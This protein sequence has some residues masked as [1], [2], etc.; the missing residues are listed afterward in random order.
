MNAERY[1]LAKRVP[2]AFMCLVGAPVLG[3]WAGGSMP[4]PPGNG[5]GGGQVVV[6][7]AVPAILAFVSAAVARIRPAGAALWAVAS[8]APTGGLVLVLLWFVQT[9]V[10]T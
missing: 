10:P 3:V 2:L 1:G 9:Y 5:P 4:N 7:V 6:A 8:L